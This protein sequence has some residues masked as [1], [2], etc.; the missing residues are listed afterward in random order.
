MIKSLGEET[1]CNHDL[2][3]SCAGFPKLA[4]TSITSS[5]SV[6]YHLTGNTETNSWHWSPGQ[7]CW[8]TSPGISGPQDIDPCQSQWISKL[9][10]TI[11]YD[12]FELL[13]FKKL[14]FK[15]LK[16]NCSL[17]LQCSLPSLVTITHI[18]WTKSARVHMLC[19]EITLIKHTLTQFTV[20][21][22]ENLHSRDTNQLTIGT[23]TNY[24]HANAFVPNTHIQHQIHHNCSRCGE[25]LHAI[26]SRFGDRSFAAAG[27]RLW[28]SLPISLRQI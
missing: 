9:R 15:K 20:L 12:T 25:N 13:K 22:H 17:V 18:Q 1:F 8:T 2:T 6:N 16:L 23:T 26:F 28:N 4:N 11:H 27:P 19:I 21:S 7:C 10:E 3:S 24:S 14:N 5:Q